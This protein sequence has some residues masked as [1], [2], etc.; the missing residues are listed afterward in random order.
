MTFFLTNSLIFQYKNIMK[1]LE[2]GI[3]VGLW[4]TCEAS[5]IL[6]FK[7]HIRLDIWGFGRGRRWDVRETWRGS[8]ENRG[9]EADR[10]SHAQIFLGMLMTT[11]CFLMSGLN[12]WLHTGLTDVDVLTVVIIPVSSVRHAGGWICLN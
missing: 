2:Q 10:R 7:K 9:L 8:V 1:N 5:S 11:S 4:V 12:L 6:T 3:T